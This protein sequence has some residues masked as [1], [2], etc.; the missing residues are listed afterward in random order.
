MKYIYL[1]LLSAILLTSCGGDKN[2]SIDDII[3]SKDIT[4]IEA[5][6]SELKKQ[7]KE[8]SGNLAKIE[9][10]LDKLSGKKVL[11]LI[12]TLTIKE[13]AFNHFLEI[14]GNVKTKQN[15]VLYP[16]FSGTLT[17]VYVKEGQKVN[18]GQTLAKID[19]GG[20][21]MQLSQAK[22]QAALAK[23]TYERQKRLWDQKIG[24][25]IQF[26]Q[27]E[28]TFKATQDAVRQLES[29]LGKTF[30]KAPFS[31]IIDD[32]ISDEGS[33]VAPGQ[34]AL[35]RIVNLNNMYIEAEVPESHLPN[36][37]K[38]KTVEVSFP[39]L[40]K[41]IQNSIRQVGHFINP[42]NRAFKIEVGVPN[43]DGDI[44]PNLT[45]KLKINDY[46]NSKAILIP[47]SIISENSIGEQYVFIVDGVND[48]KVGKAKKTI[49]TTGKTQGDFIEV[50][51]GLEAGNFV[52]KEGA[53]S[54]QDEQ[55]I[56]ISN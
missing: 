17:R 35:L 54:V 12:T 55:E 42:N 23:T 5:K 40:G 49:I 31:G 9:A 14:Q 41:T 25:E 6:R 46:T 15:I 45:G 33:V 11:P 50:L 8:I 4:K 28:T 22:T 37:T 39:A 16:E 26:L 27:A 2:K 21:S 36:V 44:K 19:D 48:N 18:K 10:E 32:V 34:S 53:R 29:Q 13:E 43:I 3:A 1:T 7:Q 47:Q 56:E 20:L 52:I 30:V 51:T 38:G 24:S